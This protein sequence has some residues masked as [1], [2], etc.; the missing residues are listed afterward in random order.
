MDSIWVFT[1]NKDDE[2]LL[3][4]AKKET[5]ISAD[6]RPSS[7]ESYGES[8]LTIW[9]EDDDIGCALMCALMCAFLEVRGEGC[10]QYKEDPEVFTQLRLSTVL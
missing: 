2:K 6:H 9:C 5:G 3:N 10:A 8:L 7:G 1:I 4:Q